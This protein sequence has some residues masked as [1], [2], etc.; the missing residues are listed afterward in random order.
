M[1]TLQLD[2]K[3]LKIG[4]FYE[5]YSFT[6]KHKDFVSKLQSCTIWFY[7]MVAT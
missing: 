7:N 1:L 2:Y 3:I 6:G 5:M 4:D